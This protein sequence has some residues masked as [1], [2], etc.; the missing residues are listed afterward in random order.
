LSNRKDITNMYMNQDIN[1]HLG[2]WGLK[3]KESDNYQS[4]WGFCDWKINPA[5]GNVPK[6]K[7]PK[8]HTFW[9]NNH[10][11]VLEKSPGTYRKVRVSYKLATHPQI[12]PFW[13]PNNSAS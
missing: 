12:Y 13:R 2:W 10:L 7:A 8:S 5:D 6:V 11:Q 4:V 3:L 1:N 9:G